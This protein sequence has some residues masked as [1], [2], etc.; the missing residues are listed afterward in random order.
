[1]RAEATSLVAEAQLTNITRQKFKEAYLV[2][3]AAV[4]ERSEKQALLARHARRLIELL[5]D[6]AV[7][8]GE[9]HQPFQSF[10][11]AKYILSDAEEEL[12]NWSPSWEEQEEQQ[13]QRHAEPLTD[14]S[15]VQSP[16]QA[17]EAPHHSEEQQQFTQDGHGSLQPATQETAQVAAQPALA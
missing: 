11:A 4:L 5:D 8:P 9:A 14:Q 6:A 15:M 13:Q 17:A 12:R 16:T 7:V 3:T 10:E 1:M 2:H